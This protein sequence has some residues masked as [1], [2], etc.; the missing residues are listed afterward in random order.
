ML[1]AVRERK[2]EFKS[3]QS[4]GTEEVH[5]QYREKNR[6]AKRRRKSKYVQGSK[7]DDDYDEDEY[8]IRG[9]KCFSKTSA[10]SDNFSVRVPQPEITGL[11]GQPFL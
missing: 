9:T 5:E 3:W 6:Q 10:D 4:E 8:A 7:A 11:P 1:L 2:L